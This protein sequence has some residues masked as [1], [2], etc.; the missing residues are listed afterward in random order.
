MFGRVTLNSYPGEEF[1]WNRPMMFSVLMSDHQ[2]LLPYYP[3]L[4]VVILVG[5][6]AR[7]S[8]LAAAGFLLLVL[9]FA[10]LYGYWWSWHLGQGFG[11]RGFVDLVPFA[12]P[13]FATALTHLSSHW[14]RATRGIAVVCIG[15]TGLTIGLMVN[16]W[17]WTMPS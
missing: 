11:H 16:Y 7:P 3:V 12:V 14:P 13:L 6:I 15:L 9:A 2:G 8:R 10:A 17:Y 4:A 1:L 5:L